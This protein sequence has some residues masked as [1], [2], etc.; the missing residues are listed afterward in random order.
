M[1]S[2]T[3]FTVMLD[4]EAEASSIVPRWPTEMTVT[5]R[6]EYSSIWV[7][8]ETDK[9][10][11]ICA[12]DKVFKTLPNIG[13]V[14]A[15]RI[16]SSLLYR[17]Y[18]VEVSGVGAGVGGGAGVRRGVASDGNLASVGVSDTWDAE[19]MS[20]LSASEP[21]SSSSAAS[22]IPSNRSPELIREGS[23]ETR[24]SR[25]FGTP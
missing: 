11:R 10:Q 19:A 14:Y 21:A 9:S 5:T 23:D 7:P 20:S 17:A 3:T 8:A 6:R 22:S 12:G 24:L 13:I 2:D 4:K 1:E 16:L 25:R 15:V 18:E